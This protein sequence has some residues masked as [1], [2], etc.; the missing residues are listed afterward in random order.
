MAEALRPLISAWVDVLC[1]SILSLGEDRDRRIW[2][3]LDELASLEPS[4]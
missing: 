2:M 3:F 1:T 4:A